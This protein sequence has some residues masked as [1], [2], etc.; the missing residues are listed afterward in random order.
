[1][2]SISVWFFVGIAIISLAFETLLELINLK[3]RKSKPAP[4]VADIFNEEAYNKQQNYEL[5]TTRFSLLMSALSNLVVVLLL[6]FGFFGWL[7]GFVALLNFNPVFTSLVFFFVLLLAT[8]ILSLP[9]SL[10]STFVIEKRFGFNKTT[11][12]LFVS[13]QFKSLLLSIVIGGVLLFVISFLFYSM[14]K[15]F[16]LFALLVMVIFS[17]IANLFYTR[18]I[19]PIFNKM[20]P[21]EEGSLRRLIIDFSEKVGFSINSVFVID[22]SKRS[23]KANAF[24]SGFGRNRRIVI[25]DTLMEKLNEKEVLAVVAHEVGHYK[26]KHLWINL[27]LG[28]IQS[29]IFL[30]LFNLLSY[31]LDVSGS[32]GYTAIDGP[33]FHLTIIGFGIL[34]SPLGSLLGIFTNGLSRRMEFQADN[35]AKQNSLNEELVS[36]L[37]KLAKENLSNLTPHPLYVFVHYSHPPLDERLKK[38]T[39]EK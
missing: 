6:L 2:T 7:H 35:F 17:I 4:L 18:I 22:G 13:D 36:G 20:M 1:M 28:I 15:W 30:Y 23:T 32:L 39:G 38:L 33:I 5:V 14:G 3:N 29:S 25:Y 12:K 21:L 19:I 31:S 9:F 27:T 37:K 10:Y 34:F 11:L 24:F 26:K 16:W 8:K